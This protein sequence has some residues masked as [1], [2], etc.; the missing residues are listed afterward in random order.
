[1]K[2]KL[3]MPRIEGPSIFSH[4]TI[5]E[6]MDNKIWLA[7]LSLPT[8]AALTPKD[9]E[10]SILD[11]NVEPVDFNENIDLV[12]ISAFTSSAMR[13]YE[14]ADNFRNRGVKVVLGGIHPSALP[15]EAISHAD[16]VVIGEAENSWSELISDFRKERLRNFYKSSSRADF[17]KSVI[18]RWDL[19]KMDSYR[20]FLIQTTRGCPFNCSFCSVKSFLGEEYRFKP[21]ENVVEEI[22]AMKNLKNNISLFFADDNFAAN[23]KRTKELLL[24]FSDLKIKNW[25]AQIS[26][27]TEDEILNLMADNG[28]SHVAIGLE[29]LSQKTIDIMGKGRI[30]KVEEYGKIVDRIHSYGMGV[31]AT[32]I[33]GHD[34]EDINIFD[35]IIQ[36]VGNYNIEF[37]L[38]GLLTPFPGTTIAKQLHQE[39]R[40]IDNDWRHYDCR[41]VCFKPNS[42]S[43][44][45]LNRRIKEVNQKLYS[46]ESLYDRLSKSWNRGIFCRKTNII[47]YVFNKYRLKFSLFAFKLKDVKRAWFI[48]RSLW[49]ISNPKFYSIFISLNIHDI[50]YNKI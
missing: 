42:I 25:V 49:H 10:I 43:A 12:G 40:I 44:E 24:A 17:K 21:I 32:F 26:I 4:R 38:V 34:S 45:E 9:I 5:P 39:N 7:P 47:E 18:P 30:N 22:K 29:S 2:L 6:F 28:C 46:Y 48:L 36:F 15:E 14:I 1:M 37:P 11:E 19:L 3:I 8:I 20:A 41:Y 23:P 35:E 33:T 50:V 31:L 13:A 27:N 16:A